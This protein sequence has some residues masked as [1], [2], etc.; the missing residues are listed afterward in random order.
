M[1]DEELRG[2][3]LE[4]Y[5]ELRHNQDIVQFEQIVAIFLMKRLGLQI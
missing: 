1:K 3:V 5:H 4:K 2:L